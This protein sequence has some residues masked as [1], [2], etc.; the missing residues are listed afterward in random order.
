MYMY[1][2]VCIFMFTCTPTSQGQ[3]WPANLPALP[4][5]KRATHQEGESYQQH[6]HCTGTCPFH[7][8]WDT[9]SLSH[10]V[11]SAGRW[12]LWTKLPRIDKP[13]LVVRI[14]V[15]VCG[16]GGAC[17]LSGV[18]F[19]C[20]CDFWALVLVLSASKAS[21]CNW[22]FDEVVYISVHFLGKKNENKL[23]LSMINM[24]LHAIE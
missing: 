1:I 16:M 5:A 18:W 13:V 17:V 19:D 12:L 7:N 11:G 20:W 2:H 8:Q 21:L 22:I 9:L 6:L 23:Y 15:L 14:H 3:R 24:T 10:W 4:S